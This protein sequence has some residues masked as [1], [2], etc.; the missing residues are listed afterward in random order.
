M[1]TESFRESNEKVAGRATLNYFDK[2]DI[3]FGKEVPSF[4]IK[5]RSHVH[6]LLGGISSVIILTLMLIYA[7]SS[8]IDFIQRTN[9]VKNESTI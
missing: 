5:G 4:T 8:F 3:F 9:P 7:T 1:L 6:T 2:F